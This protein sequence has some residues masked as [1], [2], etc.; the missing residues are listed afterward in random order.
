MSLLRELILQIVNSQTNSFYLNEE[1][2]FLKHQLNINLLLGCQINNM[3]IN[4]RRI[5]Q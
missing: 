1:D 2:K 3:W 5:L 4:G